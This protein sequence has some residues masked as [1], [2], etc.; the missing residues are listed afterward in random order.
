MG[1]RVCSY[2]LYSMYGYS[3]T[4]HRYV[5]NNSLPYQTWYTVYNVLV[6]TISRAG[7]ILKNV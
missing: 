1:H 3:I 7:N 6:E 4:I 5:Y 2:L